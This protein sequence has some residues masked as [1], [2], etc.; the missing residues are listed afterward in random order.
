MRCGS[1]AL[2]W[3]L[4]DHRGAVGA[5]ETFIGVGFRHGSDPRADRQILLSA[6][7]RPAI[8]NRIWRA[9]R[10]CR[11]RTRRRHEGR[12]PHHECEHGGQVRLTMLHIQRSISTVHRC[13]IGCDL[14]EARG[15]D[16][17]TMDATNKLRCASVS[18]GCLVRSKSTGDEPSEQSELTSTSAAPMAEMR[19]SWS[20]PARWAE[21]AGAAAASIRICPEVFLPC[22]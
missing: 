5:C 16:V 11:I 2:A 10:R 17:T 3:T 15:R 18:P 1:V 20:I 22:L 19:R 14:G 12:Q 4:G 9:C 7:G 13:Q 21:S 8:R 6:H